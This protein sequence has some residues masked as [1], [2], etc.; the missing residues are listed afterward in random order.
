[1]FDFLI[2]GAGLFG[3]VSAH[4]LTKKGYKCLVIDKRSHLGGNCYTRKLEGIN[5]HEYGPH[6]FNTNNE[7][8]WKYVNQY[9]KFN[10]F[11]YSP[12][13]KYKDELYSLP[14]NMWTF[15]KIWN[16]QTPDE[17]YKKIRG[18]IVKIE[19]PKNLE[20]YVI[21][22]LGTVIYEKLIKHYT[23]KQW[24]RDP[25]ELP[26]FIIKRLPYRLTYDNNYFN[27]SYCGIP[28]NGYTEI[29]ENML[30]NIE[31][32][33]EVDYFKNRDKLN[34]MAR[35]IIYTGKIDEFFEYKFGQLDYRTLK[36]RHEIKD[37]ENFQG[38]PVINHTCD[39]FDY[40]RTIEHK[41]FEKK[42]KSKKTILTYETPVLWEK[43]LTPYYPINDKLNTAIYKQY[44]KTAE[45]MDNVIFG[46]RLAK[47]F[48]Y[49]MD[50]VIGSA[51]SITKKN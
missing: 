11:T 49:N 28:K 51:L 37:C 47:Y 38:V 10:Q 48:Y 2:V 14:F 43:N 9:T 31:V 39:T 46:G 8:I 34:S 6:I 21:S 27:T 4:E 26:A 16:V 40:T 7:K 35:N 1:M 13:A 29:F 41:H 42:I 50:Q 45:K 5:V 18:T 19:E 22:N 3:S 32:R 20:E 44:N 15:N 24:M 33:L 17:A 23:K 30:Q 36:F 25:S 12:V